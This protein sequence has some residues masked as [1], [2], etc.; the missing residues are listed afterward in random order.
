MPTKNIQKEL[1][2]KI[3]KLELENQFLRN[4]LN[5]I[6]NSD[7]N[8]ISKLLDTIPNP[9]FYKDI[10]G[11]YQNCNDAFSKTI[12][13]IPKEV[14]I[15]KSLFDLPEYIPL[16]LAKTYHK[17]DTEL[18]NTKGIQYYEGKV[19][20]TDNIVRYYSFHKA[21]VKNDN[22]KTIG[23]VGVMLDI[24]E[25]KKTQNELINTNKKLEELTYIDSLT[26]IFNRRK[27]DEVFEKQINLAER[28][29]T[30]INFI[31]LDLD[32][33][34]SYN[35]TYGH[36][37][38]D[39][40]LKQVSITLNTMLGRPDDYLFRIGGEEFGILYHSDD[41]KKAFH[42]AD[43]IRQN[44]EDLHI[45]H[46]KNSIHKRVTASL[47]LLTIKNNHKDAR[48]IYSQTDALLYEAKKIGRNCIKHKTI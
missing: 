38:G 3:L 44:I 1:K 29:N 10:Y 18:F 13:G 47:G 22:N 36:Q 12:L 9:F 45:E 7:E 39:N 37:E 26:G 32:N 21:T 4:T 6:S 34:K 23:I 27:F 41:E 2:N 14:I 8:F 42:F 40:V 43:N 24:S 46:K 16:S 31:M 15:G 33:F 11:V 20:C 48:S 17:K 5:N 30:L 19:K 35:D 25:L 28:H